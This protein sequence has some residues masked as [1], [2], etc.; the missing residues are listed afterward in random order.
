M[1]ASTRAQAA[2]PLPPLLLGPVDSR[3]TSLPATNTV[4]GAAQ[5]SEKLADALL[6]DT[7]VLV[8]AEH[9]L[10]RGRGDISRLTALPVGVPSQRRRDELA[11][12]ADPLPADAQGVQHLVGRVVARALDRATQLASLFPHE[13]DECGL[14]VVLGEVGS[15]CADRVGEPLDERAV[16]GC[17]ERLEHGRAAADRSILQRAEQGRARGLA[18]RRAALAISRSSRSSSTSRSRTGPSAPPSQPSS[19]RR[20]S[21]H[22]ASR[23][24]WAAFNVARMRRT[25]TRI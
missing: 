10:Q 16:A 17:G 1:R 18:R 3:S 24:G 2:S 20:P 22:A 25:A 4:A 9:L 21:A 23:S 14:R 13:V 6:G 12:I 19:A 15:G 11:R 5:A 8:V 7:R